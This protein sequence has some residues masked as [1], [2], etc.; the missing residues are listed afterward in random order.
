MLTSFL[1]LEVNVRE[2]AGVIYTYYAYYHDERNI[3]F[4]IHVVTPLSPDVPTCMQ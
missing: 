2:D 3:I 1:I 4:I